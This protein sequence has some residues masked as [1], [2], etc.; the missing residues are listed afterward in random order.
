MPLAGQLHVQTARKLDPHRLAGDLRGQRG[1]GGVWIS[2]S[3]FAAETTAHAQAP[4]HRAMH[5]DAEHTRD[6]DLGFGRVLGGGHGLTMETYG[7]GRN[8]RFVARDRTGVVFARHVVGGE[9]GPHPRHRQRGRGVDAQ[10]A[11]MRLCRLNRTQAQ[12]AERFV[13]LIGINGP[14]GDMADRAFVLGAHRQRSA[15]NFANRLPQ[16]LRR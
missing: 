9:H 14:T 11:G 4:A 13:L 6:D 8:Q 12:Q 2:L 5:R 15:T 3:F 16:S 7:V 1:E 10:N